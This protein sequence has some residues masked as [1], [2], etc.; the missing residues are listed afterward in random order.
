MRRRFWDLQLFSRRRSALSG[1][2]VGLVLG[3]L[4]GAT[5]ILLPRAS[6]APNATLGVNEET[7][8]T[9]IHLQGKPDIK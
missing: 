1:F 3:C 8:K 4:V 9:Q 7:G 6:N 5:M 2:V